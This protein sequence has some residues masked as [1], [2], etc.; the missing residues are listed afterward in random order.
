MGPLY[1]L[2][3]R[4]DRILAWSE[5]ARVVRPGGVVAAAA[6]SRFAS[7]IDGLSGMHLVQPAFQAIVDTDIRTGQH[8]NPERRHRWFTTSYFH[9]PDE[10]ADEMSEVGLMAELVAAVEGPGQLMRDSVGAWLDDPVLRGI[11]LESIARVETEPTML[12]STAHL[13][14]AGRRG[15]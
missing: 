4:A 13:F 11:L 14:A 5:A 9:H 7:L 12:G 8:R 3:E 1:H 2:T 15:E 6:I 10:L